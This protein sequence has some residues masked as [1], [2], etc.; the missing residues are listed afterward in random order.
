MYVVYSL[1]NLSEATHS[2]FLKMTVNANFQE[3][4]KL[5]CDFDADLWD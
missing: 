4:E 5:L 1:Y 3:V 2:P